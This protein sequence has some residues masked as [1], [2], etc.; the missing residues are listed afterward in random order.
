MDERSTRSHSNPEDTDHA[1]PM[2][3]E[4]KVLPE[5]F[6]VRNNNAAHDDTI[7]ED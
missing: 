5:D 7:A 2:L 1:V 4:T 3:T 6:S